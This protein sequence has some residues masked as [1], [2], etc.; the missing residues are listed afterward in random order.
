MTRDFADAALGAARIACGVLH[1]SPVD[2][3]GATPAEL[4]TALE[5]R[6]GG[7][8]EAEGI[9]GAAMAQLMERFPDGR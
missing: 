8:A 9:D 2:F 5:G 4:A 6:L 3:W 7:G 1:W